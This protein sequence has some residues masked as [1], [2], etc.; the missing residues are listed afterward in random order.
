MLC[1]R[2]ALALTFQGV[3]NAESMLG[4][5]PS[6]GTEIGQVLQ[7]G[8]YGRWFNVALG[9]SGRHYIFLRN[10]P[11]SETVIGAHHHSVLRPRGA[12]WL[13]SQYGRGVSILL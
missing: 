10:G 6:R 9:S 7:G 12:I 8:V 13:S 4:P 5:L 1:S 11:S 3:I 2:S